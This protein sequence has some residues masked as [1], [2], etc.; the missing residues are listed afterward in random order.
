MGF[1]WG[2][3]SADDTCAPPA[4]RAPLLNDVAY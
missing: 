4:P 3:D 1:K 2:N